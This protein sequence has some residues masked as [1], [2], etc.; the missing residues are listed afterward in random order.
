MHPAQ[1]LPRAE[2]LLADAGEEGGQ[3]FGIEIEQIDAALHRRFD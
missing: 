1:H 2:G 3:A